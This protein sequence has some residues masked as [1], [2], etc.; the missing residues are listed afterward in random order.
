MAEGAAR[1]QRRGSSRRRRRTK[2]GGGRGRRSIWQSQRG[3][4][5]GYCI[6]YGWAQRERERE[7]ERDFFLGGWGCCFTF[8]GGWHSPFS[9]ILPCV[10]MAGLCAFHEIRIFA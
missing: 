9:F 3:S 5:H 1:E 10:S 7:R 6:K 4:S 2:T 8:Y